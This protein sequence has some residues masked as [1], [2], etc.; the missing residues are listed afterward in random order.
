[1]ISTMTHYY[2]SR[3]RIWLLSVDAFLALAL[4]VS[5]NA[6]ASPDS[7]QAGCF[8]PSWN[9]LASRDCCTS[10]TYLGLNTVSSFIIPTQSRESE[11][12]SVPTTA[13]QRRNFN[14]RQSNAF[15]SLGRNVFQNSRRRMVW[16]SSPSSRH[17]GKTEEEIGNDIENA[18]NALL[19]A[20]CV[21]FD[22]DSTVIQEEGYDVLAEYLGKGPDVAALTKQ[23]MNGEIKF[24]DALSGRLQ[25]IQPSKQLIESCLI[26][27]PFKLS[28]NVRELIQTLKLFKK[29][30]YL[31]S[32]GLRIMIEPIAMKLGIPKENII[33]NTI[34][35]DDDG[36]Y[37][38][39]DV[40][41]PTSAD[42]GKARAIQ[43][44]MDTKNYKCVVMIGDGMT[45]TQA[46]PP[47]KSII[48]YGGVVVREPVKNKSDW[49]ITDFND[50]INHL[51]K[52]KN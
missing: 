49:F 38:G 17:S 44:I 9:A 52:S 24:Q 51:N 15:S 3:R 22:V 8:H 4:L 10:S 40:N 35:F 2:T 20:D 41:E 36:L 34:L 19:D 18:K 31:V 12:S 33:A 5:R 14:Q 16:M 39:F 23:T 6:I 45:D 13:L 28:P 30:V 21:C 43:S 48:G 29:D 50:I 42:M 27:R 46:K 26:D 1:M 32:G 47:A 7:S 11:E 25:L 37:N